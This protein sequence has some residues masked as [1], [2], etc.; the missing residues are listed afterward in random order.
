M[1]TTT[2]E[3][4]SALPYGVN[5]RVLVTRKVEG[6]YRALGFLD[7]CADRSFAFVYLAEAVTAD[8]FVPL[9]GLG[10]TSHVHRSERLFPI[11]ASRVIGL[12]RPDRPNTLEVLDLALES[13]PFE[14]LERSGGRRVGDAIEVLPVPRIDPSGHLRVEFFVHGVRYID[15]AA[16]RALESLAPGDL[17]RLAPEPDNPA[18]ARA[19]CVSDQHANFRL[20]YVPAP[21]T[22]LVGDVLSTHGS[23]L[24]VVRANGAEAGFHFRLLVELEGTLPAGHPGPFRS[25]R[26]RTV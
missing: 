16:L 15:E 19:I 11:F 13:T 17:L 4:P 10:N 12:G 14:I 21:L 2:L 24:R 9:P 22:G 1:S 26:W 6:I 7:E 18:D 20:G 25:E 5:R 3:R 8:W 23:T